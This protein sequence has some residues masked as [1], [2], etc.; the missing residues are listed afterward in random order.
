MYWKEVAFISANKIR[1]QIIETIGSSNKPLT[2]TQIATVT[3]IA[4][5]NVSSKLLELNSRN[6]IKCLN[7]EA[8]K[9]RIYKL[10]TK[11]KR[12]FEKIKTLKNT[13]SVTRQKNL[14]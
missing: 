2:P 4:R 1:K 13:I 6:L 7:P 3:K 12:V 11:G 9:F 14:A 5:S 8:R 10:T